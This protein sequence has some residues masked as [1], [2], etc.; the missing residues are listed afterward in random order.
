MVIFS[1][2]IT[3]SFSLYLKGNITYKYTTNVHTLQTRI[4]LLKG[5]NILS[6][7]F[8]RPWQQLLFFIW[9]MTYM[10]NLCCQHTGCACRRHPALQSNAVNVQGVLG[11]GTLGHKVML[12][13]YRVCL[14]KA[15]WVNKVTLLLYRVCMEKVPWFPGL[16]SCWSWWPGWM[17]LC[18]FELIFSW[19]YQECILV[20]RFKW[21]GPSR[22]GDSSRCWYGPR[23]VLHLGIL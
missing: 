19:R 5:L 2:I 18:A 13:L 16:E 14:M 6:G 9:P 15:P 12:L 23:W 11:K 21:V 22:E 17:C 8:F 3:I 7:T 1:D 10:G 20:S 4:T